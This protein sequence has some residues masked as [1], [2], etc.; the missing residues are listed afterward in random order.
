ML[1]GISAVKKR[2]WHLP[3]DSLIVPKIRLDHLAK[4]TKRGGIVQFSREDTPEYSSGYCVDDVSRLAI[5][6]AWFERFGLA[7]KYT[8]EWLDHS[9]AILAQAYDPSTTMMYNMANMRGRWLDELHWGDHV[10]R[11]LWAL[12]EVVA[13]RAVPASLRKRAE[14]LM[15]QMGKSII[16]LP[17]LRPTAEAAVGLARL[18]KL[19][20]KQKELLRFAADR[21]SLAYEQASDPSWHWFEDRLTYDNARLPQGLILAA[22]ALKDEKLLNEG[23][24]A[25]DWLMNECNKLAPDGVTPHVGTIGNWWLSRERPGAGAGSGGGD[26]QPLEFTAMIETL[27][28]AYAITSHQKYAREA[29]KTF[30]WFLGAN[31]LDKWLYDPFTGGSQDGLLASSVV[32]TN[33]GAESTLA[34]YQS[35]LCLAAAELISIE[36]VALEPKKSHN[37]L[38]HKRPLAASEL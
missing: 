22:H 11:T 23:L 12:G 14:S 30:G 34:Y 35:L 1:R 33:M 32:N 4:M 7:G 25:L 6:A 8:R 10:G 2:R 18:P 21:L 24:A 16:N 15:E 37:V 31:R 26:E 36:T 20:A 9:L 13:V 38:K 27:V 28:D 17:A 29:L 19:S 5:V 3:T